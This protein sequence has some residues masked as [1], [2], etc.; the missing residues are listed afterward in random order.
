M[1]KRTDIRNLIS[2]KVL[3]M[4]SANGRSTKGASVVFAIVGFMFAAMISLVVVNA[5][6]SN[7][8]K[9]KK[10][11]YDEQASI[12]SQSMASIIV[13]A[14]A[15]DK[16]EPTIAG[17]TARTTDGSK[18]LIVSHHFIET[19][20]SVAGTNVTLYQ[21]SKTS[22]VYAPKTTLVAGDFFYNID[23]KTGVATSSAD[24]R[25]LFI[26]MAKAVKAS[27]AEVSQDISV[28]HTTADGV[29]CECTA[30]IT[31]DKNFNIEADIK[32]KAEK[33]SL[34]GAYRLN[35]SAPATSGTISDVNLGQITEN[36]T[37]G[38]IESI[39]Y[40]AAGTAD[41]DNGKKM[42]KRSTF[43]VKWPQDQISSTYVSF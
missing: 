32:G 20:D 3:K 9:V 25:K 33:G 36:A 11:R 15:G 22:G 29:V 7:A 16:V 34:K 19:M 24:M 28:S 40:P 26:A 18:G 13:N 43:Y 12:I 38:Q 42:V 37:T 17:V 30:S 41:P 23:E 5:A 31:M 1:K 2:K 35:L 14:L 4:R 21:T 6:Y 39:S 8:A 10:Q 27:D